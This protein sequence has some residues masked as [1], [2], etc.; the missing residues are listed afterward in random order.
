MKL[1]PSHVR[2]SRN[3]RT[4]LLPMICVALGAMVFFVA[5]EA[6]ACPAC[7]CGSTTFV[8]QANDVQAHTLFVETQATSRG[9]S[10]GEGLPWSVHEW[11]L[12]V[13]M[14]WAYK[15]LSLTG[16]L[17]FI[18][19]TASF[20]GFQTDK[21]VGIGDVEVAGAYTLTRLP[22][23]ETER[24]A[25][26]TPLGWYAG[27]HLGLSLPTAPLQLDQ[28]DRPFIDDVQSGTGSFMPFGGGFWSVGLR[29]WKIDQRHTL[30]LPIPGRFWF[31]VGPTYQHRTR[32][33]AEPFKQFQFGL[34]FYTT[35]TTPVKEDGEI[36]P[37]ADSGG[38]AGY[39]DL[40]AEF[41]PHDQL[42]LVVGGRFP[43]IQKLSG[44]HEA[45]MGMY[46]ALRFQQA[47]RKKQ[48]NLAPMLL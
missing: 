20:K 41:V 14:G 27:V 19:R 6:W 15:R 16:R 11:R 23:E 40:E 28:H 8:G 25:A 7:G 17:P 4:S 46:V 9:E 5:A 32:L 21:T 33:M 39:L 36:E 1:W 22:T 18:W 31:H 2:T 29:G 42:T 30:Y 38:F 24:N 10:F 12:D 13:T 37:I 45:H 26:G 3:P 34:G 43:V 48:T 47:I 35:W 44:D